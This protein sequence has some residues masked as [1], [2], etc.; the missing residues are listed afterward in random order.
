MLGSANVVKSANCLT[1]LFIK[2]IGR[3]FF[4]YVLLKKWLTAVLY[5]KSKV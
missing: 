5:F 1:L 3:T 2:L 4:A